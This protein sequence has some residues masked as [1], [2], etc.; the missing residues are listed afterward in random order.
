MRGVNP[1]LMSRRCRMWSV[2]SMLT[3]IDPGD[4]GLVTELRTVKC[5]ELFGVSAHR[6]DVLVLRQ[7]PETAVVV[8]GEPLGKCLPAAPG[9]SCRSLVKISWGKPLA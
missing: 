1:A 2:P 5:T 8:A 6:L 7:D 3:S 9:S 4:L